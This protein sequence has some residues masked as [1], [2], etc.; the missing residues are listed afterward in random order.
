[1]SNSDSEFLR[2]EWREC[3]DYTLDEGVQEMWVANV[4]GWTFCAQITRE[5]HCDHT[6][7]LDY[8]QELPVVVKAKT[9]RNGYYSTN[10]MQ[11]TARDMLVKYANEISGM[12]FH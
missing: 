7:I 9:T 12:E 1:M 6:Y 3:T 11:E 2:V 8:D 4:Q 5:Q 10:R